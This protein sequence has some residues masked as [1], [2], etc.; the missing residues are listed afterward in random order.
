[1][2]LIAQSCFMASLYKR[3]SYLWLEFRDA[4]GSRVQQSTQLRHANVH[5][6]RQA[7]LLCE[8]AGALER[9][10]PVKSNKSVDSFS[11]W[12]VRFLD[13]RYADRP[14]THARVLIEWR[15]VNDFLSSNG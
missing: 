15:T 6:A 14:I 5:E 2:N 11:V 12:V 1:M 13:Q 10:S 7:R 4:S 3:G 9:T 8:R